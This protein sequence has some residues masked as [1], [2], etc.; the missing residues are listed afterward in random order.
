M[1]MTSPV[2]IQTRRALDRPPCAPPRQN[3]ASAPCRPRTRSGSAT[4]ARLD[5]TTMMITVNQKNHTTS[6]VRIRKK[7]ES[8]ETDYSNSNRQTR[9]RWSSAAPVH[10]QT[11]STTAPCVA[12]RHRWHPA[13]AGDRETSETRRAT[14]CAA[15][16]HRRQSES[17]RW[18]RARRR[19]L[20]RNGVRT[21]L[22]KRRRE[23]GKKIMQRRDCVLLQR[24][25][26]PSTALTDGASEGGWKI[27][28][29]LV[30]NG[31]P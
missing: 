30:K 19:Q 7:N 17:M 29:Q 2:P 23:T 18:P 20:D 13:P 26:K 4:R 3:L 9:A 12:G 6:K 22:I 27:V 21:L 8:T 5:L 10:R 16:R 15:P 11:S 14:R 25:G 28:W 24:L 1:T 31:G